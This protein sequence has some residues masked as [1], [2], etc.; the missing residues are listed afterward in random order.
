MSFVYKGLKANFE[1]LTVTE[2]E[3]DRQMDRL[4]QQTPRVIPVTERAAK[5]GDDVV[6]D[7]AGFVDGKQFDGGTAKEQ[8]LTLGSGMFIPGFE[9][10]LVG[11]KIG[12]DVVV[13]V[14]FPKDYRAENLAGKEAEF[15]CKIHEI[16]EKSAYALDDAFARE[17]GQCPTLAALRSRLKESLQAYYDECAEMELQDQLMRQAAATLDYTPAKDELEKAMDAQLE[18]LRAQLAQ[19]GLTLEAYC[20]FTGAKED[21]LREDTRA[22]A[23]SALRIQHAAERIALLEGIRASDEEVAE[24]L[25]GICQQNGMTIEQLR[26]YMNAEFEQTVAANIRMKKAIA[27]VRANADVTVVD[28]PASKD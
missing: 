15:R 1:K 18:V 2:H 23:E 8:V 25:A 14:T 11:A 20:Q 19:R 21:Q 9:E 6:L 10:Q 17:V 13:H 16:H 22:E 4:R 24:E 12:E 3:L 7:Y 26:P 5:M 28:A 27:F